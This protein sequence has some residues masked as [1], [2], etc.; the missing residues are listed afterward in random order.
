MFGSGV[1]E[2]NF[3]YHL[4]KENISTD[5]LSQQSYLPAPDY[6][7]AENSLQVA[8]VTSANTSDPEET[9]IQK[10]FF[11]L[12]KKGMLFLLMTSVLHHQKR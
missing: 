3:V 2:G 9:S 7:I 12:I 8:S 11:T 1:G 4:G 10:L 6:E 5:T